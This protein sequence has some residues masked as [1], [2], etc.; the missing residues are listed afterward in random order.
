MGNSFCE[1]TPP[2]HGY[3]KTKTCYFS[4]RQECACE[5]VSRVAHFSSKMSLF[6]EVFHTN[7]KHEWFILN[8]VY[9]LG[10]DFKHEFRSKYF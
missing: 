8:R 9:E 4:E 7:A 3:Y 6:N 5:I 1:L 2:C 10:Y